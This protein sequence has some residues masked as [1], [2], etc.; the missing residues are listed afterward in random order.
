MIE[1]IITSGQIGT[2]STSHNEAGTPLGSTL[3]RDQTPAEA[4]E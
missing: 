4:D 1:P 2:P 3:D